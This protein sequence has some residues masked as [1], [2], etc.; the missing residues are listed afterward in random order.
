VV[1]ST[2][3]DVVCGFCGCLC[4]DLEVEVENNRI[5]QVKSACGIG[6]NKLLH[7]Q[8]GM[9]TI[10]I[11]GQSASL[12]DA[13]DEAAR[14]LIAA[15]NPLIYGLS[16]ASTE[17]QREAVALTEM[18]QGT[19]DN[20]SSYCHGPSVLAGQQVG[21]ASCTLGEVKNRADLVI[22][23]GANPAESH[24]R[25]MM[26]YSVQ[27]KGLFVPEGRKGRKVVVIDVRPTPTAKQ[28]DL[29]LQC[30][31]GQDFEIAT[32]LRALIKGL[33]LEAPPPQH[34]QRR[35]VPGT[36]FEESGAIAGVPVERWREVAALMKGCRYGVLFF[37]IGLTQSRGK[38]LNVEQVLTL[39]QELNQFTRF[40]AIPNRGHGN[41]TGS[42]QVLAW[43][44]GYPF[45]VNFS[46][47]YPRYNPGEYSVVDMLMRRDVDA[48]LIVAT[49]PGAHLPQAAV[50]HLQSIPTIFLEPYENTTSSWAKVVIPVAP[51]GVG[52]AGTFYRMDLVSLRLDKLIDFPCPSDEEVLRS[53]KERIVNAEDRERAGL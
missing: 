14:I 49:D 34:A 31:P 2:H 47:G 5:I 13:L 36:P 53:I 22:F 4:D 16:S 29:F 44:T 18:L 39:V 27:A 37:G 19:I 41:V 24:T 9:A 25:H 15:K 10:R 26:R 33:P 50:R 52:A 20:P 28:A 46:R 48:A 7:A 23:W 1:V 8:S 42:N 51:M 40:H 3:K 38:D 43:Q 35:R 21:V 30:L 17:A 32:A 12:Q 6:R 45:A 11:N